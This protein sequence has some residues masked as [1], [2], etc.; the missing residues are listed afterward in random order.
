[1]PTQHLAR[2]LLA[3]GVVLLLWPVR[4]D[5]TRSELVAQSGAQTM[6]ELEARLADPR[7]RPWLERRPLCGPPVAA[8]LTYVAVGGL[9]RG[10]AGPNG[11]SMSL[12]VLPLLAAAG[13]S[14]RRRV[15]APLPSR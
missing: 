15:G 14:A 1:M 10:C 3:V 8:P 13:L 11:R 7:Q 6:A 5:A 4:A 12:A 9:R 2:L